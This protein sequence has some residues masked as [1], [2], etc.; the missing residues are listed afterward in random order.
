VRVDVLGYNHIKHA[1]M[2][3]HIDRFMRPLFGR[4]ELAE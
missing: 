2:K 4:S 1:V 3:A